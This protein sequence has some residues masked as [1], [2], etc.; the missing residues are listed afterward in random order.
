MAR[1]SF[2]DYV[3]VLALHG[4]R[5]WPAIPRWTVP[6][7]QLKAWFTLRAWRDLPGS[8]RWHGVKGQIEGRAEPPCS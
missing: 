1:A 7:R 3:R 2:R 4:I 5:P 8:I 6:L